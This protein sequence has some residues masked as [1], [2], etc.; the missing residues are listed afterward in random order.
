LKFEFLKK[1]RQV[2]SGFTNLIGNDEHVLGRAYSILDWLTSSPPRLRVLISEQKESGVGE[3]H[4]PVTASRIC[5]Y[6][7]GEKPP[8]GPKLLCIVLL[9]VA[10]P[11]SFAIIRSPYPAKSLPPDRGHMITISDDLIVLAKNGR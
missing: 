5:K 2:H 1:D 4:G 6:M 11:H 7:K 3:V 9:F 10:A 8:A